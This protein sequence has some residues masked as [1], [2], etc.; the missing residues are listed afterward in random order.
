MVTTYCFYCEKHIDTSLENE[1]DHFDV[2]EH[3][4]YYECKEELEDNGKER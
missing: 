4:G 2:G 3:E 1:K